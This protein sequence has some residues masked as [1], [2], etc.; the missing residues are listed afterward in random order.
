MLVEF[1]K[2]AQNGMPEKPVDLNPDYVVKVEV[3]D[4]TGATEILIDTGLKLL[5]KEDRQFVV[6]RLSWFGD[7]PGPVPAPPGQKT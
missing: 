3:D 4:L 1:T 5:V 7:A 6:N 2:I